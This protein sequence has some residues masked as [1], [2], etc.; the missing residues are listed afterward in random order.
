MVIGFPDVVIVCSGN[1]SCVAPTL[2]NVLK[3]FIGGVNIFFDIH[4]ALE[5]FNNCKSIYQI[6]LMTFLKILIILIAFF[7]VFLIK[8]VELSLGD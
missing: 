6:F 3:I 8:L 2:L 7:S 1:W 5:F 4:Q